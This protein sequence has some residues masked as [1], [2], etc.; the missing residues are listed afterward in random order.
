[1]RT[2]SGHNL[3]LGRGN[4]RPWLRPPPQPHSC[5]P[6]HPRQALFGSGALRASADVEHALG[7]AE[8]AAV[9]SG[10]RLESE[11]SATRVL[12]GLGGTWRKGRFSLGARLAAHG[13]GSGDTEYSGRVSLGW[14]F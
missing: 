11:A 5:P 7:G 8:T 1:M 9:V 13:P 6:Y 12:F 3:G 10:A 14:T 2:N 4:R